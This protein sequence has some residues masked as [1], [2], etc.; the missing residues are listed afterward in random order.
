MRSASTDVGSWFVGS[1]RGAGNF[2]GPKK[3]Q[4]GPNSGGA[5]AK[6]CMPK[7]VGSAPESQVPDRLLAAGR[8]R[9]DVIQFESSTCLAPSPVVRKEGALTVVAKVHLPR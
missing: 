2:G 8:P 9:L 6:L 5:E 1:R 4:S 7:V 3:A